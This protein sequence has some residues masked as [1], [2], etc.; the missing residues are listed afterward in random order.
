MIDLREFCE[1]IGFKNVASYVQ[2]GNLVIDSPDSEELSVVSSIERGIRERFGFEV[3]VIVRSKDEFQDVLEANPFIGDQ[4]V[5]EARLCVVFLSEEPDTAKL[6]KIDPQEFGPDRFAVVG[7]H[8]YLHCPNG[9]ARTKLSNNFFENRLRVTAT[10][11]NLRTVNA[12]F[13]MLGQR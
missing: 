1:S 7:R 3:P 6:E 11:R 4:G 10:S 9:F 5:D 13:D 8:I 2:S 12:L